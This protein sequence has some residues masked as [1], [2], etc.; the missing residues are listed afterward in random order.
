[1]DFVSDSLA[2][3]RR[4]KALTIVDDFTKEPVDIALDHCIPGYYVTRVLNQAVR[5][6]GAPQAI[7]TDQGPE[8]RICSTLPEC[9]PEERDREGNWGADYGLYEDAPDTTIGSCRL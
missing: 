7:R 8:N 4:I 3:G 6:R 9:Y 2:G 5:S 1:M